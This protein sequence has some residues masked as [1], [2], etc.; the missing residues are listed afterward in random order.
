MRDFW[1]GFWTGM[2]LWWRL[3]FVMAQA[4]ARECSDFVHARGH[5]AYPA[6]GD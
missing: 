2:D 5:Y 4:A 3:V 6:K 1:N